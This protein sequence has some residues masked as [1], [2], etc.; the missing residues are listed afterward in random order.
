VALMCWGVAADRLCS[1]AESSAV[2]LLIDLQW[3]PEGATWASDWAG[4]LLVVCGVSTLFR[5]CWPVLL[6]VGVWMGLAAAAPA[7]LDEDPLRTL[8]PVVLVV[9]PLTLLLIEFWPPWLKFSLGRTRFALGLLRLSIAVSLMAQAGL[10]IREIGAPGELS[11]SLGA[12]I[13]QVSSFEYEEPAAFRVL[14]VVA[15]INVAFGL[16]VLTA[17]QRSVLF[18]TALWSCALALIPVVVHG[19]SGSPSLL[20]DV[21]RVGAPMALYWLWLMAIK[22][23]APT[24]VPA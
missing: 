20:I 4:W 14:A 10:F 16:V 2:D 8:E 21:P 7:V 13:A 19:L 23:Q 3:L 24:I 9:A 18:C 12:A 5:P 17:R 22:E 11:Q 1:G 6:P 15:A